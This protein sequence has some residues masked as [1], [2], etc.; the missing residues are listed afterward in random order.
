MADL[1]SPEGIERRHIHDTSASPFRGLP[2]GL[3]GLG[4]LLGASVLGLFGTEA[5]QTAAS[6]GV[7]LEVHAPARIRNGEF[8]EMVVTVTADRPL[9]AATL[10]VDADVW[11]DITINTVIPAPSEETARDGSFA[12][13]FGA[14]DAGERLTVKVDGQVN[15]DHAP[16]ANEGVIGVADGDETLASIEYRLEVLP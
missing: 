1:D 11:R 2:I 5:R 7:E 13:E 6:G 16:A 3:I 4:V 8:F 10:V 12:F 15:P 14:L 9:E